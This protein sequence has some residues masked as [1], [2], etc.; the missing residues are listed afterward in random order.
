[1][2]DAG[3]KLLISRQ[4]GEVHHVLL[5]LPQGANTKSVG[6]QQVCG[7]MLRP[8]VPGLPGRLG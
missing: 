1:M 4:S 6:G 3:K 2:S 8:T 7:E 5:R